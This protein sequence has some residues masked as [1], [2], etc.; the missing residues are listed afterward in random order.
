[1]R[2]FFFLI[3]HIIMASCSREQEILNQ[4]RALK[5]Q[6]LEKMALI[7]YTMSIHNM[8]LFILDETIIETEKKLISLE[9]A[10]QCDK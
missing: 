5:L 8:T 3:P 9:R 7:E 10:N 2:I 1:M 6:V 4:S